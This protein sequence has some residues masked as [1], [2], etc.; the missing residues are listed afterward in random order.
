MWHV[1]PLPPAPFS[2]PPSLIPRRYWR[3]LE[4][5]SPVGLIGPIS[6][7]IPTPLPVFQ[8]GTG[9]VFAEAAFFEEICFQGADLLVQKIVR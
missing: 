7:L 6:G 5:I 9:H 1:R 4:K 8:P 3:W 2:A